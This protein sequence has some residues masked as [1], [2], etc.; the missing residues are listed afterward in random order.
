M[1]RAW[2]LAATLLLAGLLHSRASPAQQLVICNLATSA[3]C[4]TTTNPGNGAQGQPAWVAFGTINANFELLP[5]ELF[6]E[7]PLAIVHGGTGQTTL[8]GALNALLPPQSGMAGDCLGTDGS[9]ASW[10]AC[11][12][13]GSG[14]FSA[15]TSGTNTG[16]A[17]I[18][19]TGASIAVTGTGTNQA[20][21]LTSLTGMPNQATGTVLANVS[22]G[23]TIPTAVTLTNFQAAL[24]AANAQIVIDASPGAGP[25]NDYD[26]TGYGTTTAVL[27][28]T[29]AS[30]GTTLDGLVAG[31]ALQQVF[32]INSEAAGGADLIKLVNQSSSDSTAAN[33]FLTSATSSLAIP[34]GGGV[35]CLYLAS[36]INRWWCH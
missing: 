18:V 14:A 26:P 9:T 20:T 30:G 13:G 32:I 5:S 16:A 2:L 19:G 11:G 1:N 36:T 34:A 31:S 24:T 10:I 7:L 27:Y 22:G 4:V 12:S 17:M 6:A 23:P 21:S 33:R 15:I 29:P 8:A 28:I 3:P 35:D 25:V